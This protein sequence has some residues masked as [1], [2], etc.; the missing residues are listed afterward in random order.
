MASKDGG[1]KGGKS[2]TSPTIK[3]DKG[4]G[5]KKFDKSPKSGKAKADGKNKKEE[6]A[7]DDWGADDDVEDDWAVDEDDRNKHNVDDFDDGGYTGY[8][9]MGSGGKTWQPSLRRGMTPLP[10]WVR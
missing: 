4:T 1:G 9:A 6:A 8:G 5:A 2:P 10:G 7:A 3:G